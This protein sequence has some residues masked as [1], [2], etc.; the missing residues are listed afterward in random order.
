VVELFV[1]PAPTTSARHIK[2][3]GV[4]E[5]EEGTTGAELCANPSGFYVNYHTEDLPNGAIRGQLR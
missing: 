4:V 1:P 5:P 2:Q 3:G